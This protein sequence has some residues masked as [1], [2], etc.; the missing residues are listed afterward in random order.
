MFGTTLTA[1]LVVVLVAV[2][3]APLG[4]DP[5]RTFTLPNNTGSPRLVH[6][7]DWLDDC[8]SAKKGDLV[9][10]GE[11]FKFEIYADEERAYVVANAE[12]K[13]LGCLTVH[14]A[15][16]RGGYPQSLSDLTR[17]P[18]GTPKASS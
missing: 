1:T 18:R 9:P 8:R 12:G 16:G 7:C 17:C 11:S 3:C 13:T 4:G 10:P 2:G 15:D 14:I 5:E 6:R